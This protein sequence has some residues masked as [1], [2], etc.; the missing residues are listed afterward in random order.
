MRTNID[1]GHY[2]CKLPWRFPYG[3]FRGL[4]GTGSDAAQA[5]FSLR[6]PVGG[7]A[8]GPFLSDG[9]IKVELLDEVAPHY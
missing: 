6:V 2:Y 7:S 8:E 3:F 4:P 9:A 5:E 1:G